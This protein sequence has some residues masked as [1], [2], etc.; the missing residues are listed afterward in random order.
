MRL[1]C[2]LRARARRALVGAVER[3]TRKADAGG[4]VDNRGRARPERKH[5]WEQACARASGLFFARE[6]CT[7]AALQMFRDGVKIRNLTVGRLGAPFTRLSRRVQRLHL[8]EDA[9]HDEGPCPLGVD[10]QVLHV[11]AALSLSLFPRLRSVLVR[12]AYLSKS[13]S[14]Q[15]VFDTL[16]RVPALTEFALSVADEPVDLFEDRRE[17]LL[18]LATRL[19]V[20]DARC[21][22]R[23]RDGSGD[24][25]VGLVGVM[26]ANASR[27]CVLRLTVPIHYTDLGRL[28]HV[29]TLQHLDVRDVVGDPA[30]GTCLPPN[31]FS[32]LVAVSFFDCTPRAQFSQDI[33]ASCSS[34]TLFRC[35][36]TICSEV[37][38]DDVCT[39]LTQAGR[40][41]NL[42]TLL[43]DVRAA[44]A[45]SICRPDDW[46]TLVGAMPALPR[47]CSLALTLPAALPISGSLVV[48]V[49]AFYPSLCTW[50]L[51]SA[52]PHGPSLGASVSLITLMSLLRPRPHAAALPLVL[53]SGDL[54]SHAATDR[55]GMHGY[56]P[57]LDVRKEV[58]GPQLR[59]LVCSLFPRVEFDV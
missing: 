10:V 34:R 39:I 2:V 18:E 22:M 48:L 29:P 49:L 12:D 53:D 32:G 42:D 5:V 7:D 13:P 19:Q 57:R 26:V 51:R 37:I 38:M 40:H 36:F 56:G 23:S 27:L 4:P 46:K 11:W 45:W 28:A 47:L 31:S 20:L 1:S 9:P 25:W 24:D 55:F 16:I 8:E 21:D 52:A 44:Q 33:V 17:Q 58:D 43:L 14:H 35:G 30:H 3:G 15:R 59:K 54:P 41:S 6:C 50:T